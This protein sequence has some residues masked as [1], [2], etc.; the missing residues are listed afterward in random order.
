MAKANR[1][2]GLQFKIEISFI[3]VFKYSISPKVFKKI[4]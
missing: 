1:I 4:P 3:L 2:L